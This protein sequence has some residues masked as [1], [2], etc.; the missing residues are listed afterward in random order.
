MPKLRDQARGGIAAAAGGSFQDRVGAWFAVRVLADTEASPLFDLPA[1]STLETIR[2]QTGQPIDDLGC[3]V[4]DR[5]SDERGFV[6]VQAKRSLPVSSSPT[7]D[8]AKVLDEIV[9]QYLAANPRRLDRYV[10]VTRRLTASLTDAQHILERNRLMPEGDLLVGAATTD[11][12]RAVLAI[13][14][15]HVRR[16]WALASRS[17]PTDQDLRAVLDPLFVHALDPEETQAGE[18]AALQLLRTSVVEPPSLDKLAWAQLVQWAGR[19]ARAATGTSRTKLQGFLLDQLVGLRIPRSTQQGVQ[20]LLRATDR[21]WKVLEAHE[22]IVLAGGNRVIPRTVAGD[23]EASLRRDSTIITGQPGAGKSGAMMSALR[24]L[25]D[26]GADV[27]LIAAET[28]TGGDEAGLRTELEITSSVADILRSWPGT[29]IGVLAIDGLDALRG[30]PT[31]RVIRRTVADV[32]GG[33]DRW[34]VLLSIRTYDL[35]NSELTSMKSGRSAV[36]L[37]RIVVEQLD[38]SEIDDLEAAAPELHK[39]ASAPGSDLAALL[40]NTFNLALAAQL[41]YV[42]GVPINELSPIRSQLALLDLYWQRR[43][44]DT[45]GHGDERERLVAVGCEAMIKARQLIVPRSILARVDPAVLPDVLSRGVMTEWRALPG[46][47]PARESIAFTHHVLFDY[48]AAR[49][50]R[51][52]DR[53]LVEI[54]AGDRALAVLLRPSVTLHFHYLWESRPSADFWQIALGFVTA[55]GVP[56]LAKLTAGLVAAER[57]GS[58]AEASPLLEAI[59]SPVQSTREQGELL[60]GHIVNTI[61]ASDDRTRQVV[62]ADA[63][64]W[65]E[66]AAA[67]GVPQSPSVAQSITQLLRIAI[68]DG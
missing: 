66:V 60:L 18:E 16:S 53:T 26:G 59:R 52:V 38:D 30:S 17:E 65:L 42:V 10:V 45:D 32:V 47:L 61:L 23:I 7:G 51:G 35:R 2:A 44:I 27:V 41:L 20:A 3:D 31:E 67:I 11:A 15:E 8:L 46:Q 48:S 13:L 24:R 34:R 63:G 6:F 25:R 33:D 54:L 50:L 55:A 28:L 4:K 57:V 22:S 64:P 9:R 37:T 56:D 49:L 39:L 36:P 29:G 58:L 43:V 19:L 68:A 21:S 5:A 12:E 14:R 1:T 40:R 62:G